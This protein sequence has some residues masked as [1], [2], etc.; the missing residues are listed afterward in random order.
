MEYLTLTCL[1]HPGIIKAVEL[2]AEGVGFKSIGS[3]VIVGFDRT[4]LVTEY[5]SNHS[6]ANFLSRVRISEVLA[7]IWC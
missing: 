2:V 3:E 6:L 7:K 1:E 5:A 4:S